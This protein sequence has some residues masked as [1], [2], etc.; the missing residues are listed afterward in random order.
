MPFS[1]ND[2]TANFS[3][4]GVAKSSHFDIYIHGNGDGEVERDMQYRA[5]A[6]ELPGRSIT[7]LEHSFNNYGPIN[8]IA[9]GQAYADIAV[10]FVLSEDLREKEYFE[11]WQDQMVNT[12]AF[13]PSGVA[14]ERSAMNSYNVRYFDNYSRTIVIRQYGAAGNLRSI[15][16]LNEAYPIIINPI[17]MSWGEESIMRMN[18]TFAYRNYQC[19]FNKSDQP[20]R[21]MGGSIRIDRDGISGS[22]S[23]PGLGSIAGSFEK[24]KAKLASVSAQIGSVKNKVAVIR[25]LF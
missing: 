19:V 6:T 11:I 1:A 14:R 16:T 21:G 13:N 18:V 12:G 15:H 2:I 17:A 24:G 10:S 23:I 5:D 20:E 22:I 4:T 3:K 9:Y 7:T 8:K 25:S